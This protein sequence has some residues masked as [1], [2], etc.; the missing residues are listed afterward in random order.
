MSE[1]GGVQIIVGFNTLKEVVVELIDVDTS[2]SIM[3]CLDA[4]AA[5]QF[6]NSIRNSLREIALDNKLQ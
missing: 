1:R 6:I 3:A 5:E 2:T 4:D